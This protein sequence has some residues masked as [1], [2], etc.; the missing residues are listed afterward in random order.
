MTTPQPPQSEPTPAPEAAYAAP[1]AAFPASVPVP[2]PPPV[3]Q[4]KGAKLKKFGAI[5][6]AIVVAVVVKVGIG[7]LL[8]DKPVHAKAGQCV[9]VTG[10]DNSPK[11]KTVDCGSSEANYTVVSVID[12]SFSP[13]ACDTVSGSDAGLAQQL[14]SEKFVL[15]LASKK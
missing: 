7:D 11:V 3:E 10:S 13:E 6:L 12:N 8:S 2:V 14:N 1:D 9:N 5:L 4:K 15:C